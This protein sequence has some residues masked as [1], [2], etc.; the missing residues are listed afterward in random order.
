[1][2]QFQA[3]KE[4]KESPSTPSLLSSEQSAKVDKVKDSFL[5][6]K[7]SI[8]RSVSEYSIEPSSSQGFK[9]TL[10]N[11]EIAHEL[12]QLASQDE[13]SLSPPIKQQYG[14]QALKHTISDMTVFLTSLRT[15]LDTF[16]T[17]E[18]LEYNIND[19]QNSK[20]F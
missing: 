9:K 14:I 1:M 12:Q 18:K 10:L 15:Q 8:G 11:I 7:R 17:V 2:E 13:P 3:K 6:L 20:E 5:N 4:E 19:K 16:S